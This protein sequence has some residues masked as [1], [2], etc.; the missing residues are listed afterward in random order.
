VP[1]RIVIH[2][3]FHFMDEREE[4]ELG[5][6]FPTA[7]AAIAEVKRRLD[8]ELLHM[9]RPGLTGPEL[10]NLWSDFGESP[11]ILRTDHAKPQAEFS[12]RD[13]AKAQAA[14]IA[15]SWSIGLRK[16]LVGGR[17]AIKR[18]IAASRQASLAQL[19]Q[20][21]RRLHH[22]CR[23]VL[24]PEFRCFAWRGMPAV[25]VGIKAWAIGQRGWP[26]LRVNATEIVSSGVVSSKEDLE[27]YRDE[28]RGAGGWLA[29]EQL[30]ANA[31]WR[32]ARR[33]WLWRR[34]RAELIRVAPTAMARPEIEQLVLPID[35][36]DAT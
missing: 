4:Y 18:R 22:Q 13:Y 14:V 15:T 35:L 1:Y 12:S 2:D 23:R 20:G 28:L 21:L 17:A 5:V 33:P 10:Y 11:I 36:Q 19:W 6:L 29:L 16:R 26:W 8:A 25:V 7:E 9:Y 30:A 34:G 3:L 31:L 32:E 24:L 27:M